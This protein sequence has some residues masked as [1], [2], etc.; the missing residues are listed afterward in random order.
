MRLPP[1]HRSRTAA[2]LRRI[3]AVLALGAA[4]GCDPPTIERV[5]GDLEGQ[6]CSPWSGYN[7]C[8]DDGRA[9][10]ARVAQAGGCDG[11]FESYLHCLDGVDECDWS[12]CN[13]ERMAIIDCIGPL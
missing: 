1:F 12:R 7:E 5:C 13:A 2:L 8:V 4:A 3:A 10:R 9:I 6:P 11:A